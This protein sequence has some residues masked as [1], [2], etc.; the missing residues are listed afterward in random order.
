[1]TLPKPRARKEREEANQEETDKQVQVISNEQLMHLKL[2]NI[3][4]QLDKLLK[5]C[6]DEEAKE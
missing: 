4:V 3:Q 6:L 1:M 2:D 5:L